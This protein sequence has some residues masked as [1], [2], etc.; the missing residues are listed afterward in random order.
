M[1]FAILSFLSCCVQEKEPVQTIQTSSSEPVATTSLEETEPEET[2]LEAS[3]PV[4]TTMLMGPSDIVISP[5]PIDT[6]PVTEVPETITPDGFST[7]ESADRGIRIAYPGSWEVEER[8]VSS[9]LREVV[10]NSPD[11]DLSSG[12]IVTVSVKQPYPGVSLENYNAFYMGSIKDMFSSAEAKFEAV[13]SGESTL[14]GLPGHRYSYE[15]EM[16]GKRARI[17]EVWTVKEDKVYSIRL[18]GVVGTYQRYS[19][20]YET[21][22]GS[23][24]II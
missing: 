9:Q 1:A 24:R 20:T 18:T 5:E 14:S 16:L 3:E 8:D 2:T 22:V 12:S 15:Y 21:M 17:I 23:F 19:E 4:A 10:F 11:P 6:I 7:Y 13:E